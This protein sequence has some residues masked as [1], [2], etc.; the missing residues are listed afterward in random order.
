MVK[1]RLIFDVKYD[2]RCEARLVMREHLVDVLNNNIY[3]LMVKGTSINILHVIAHQQKFKRLCGDVTKMHLC[4]HIPIK[5]I[6]GLPEFE[7]S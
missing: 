7:M 4:R 1:L 2:L 6:A 3:S 5:T